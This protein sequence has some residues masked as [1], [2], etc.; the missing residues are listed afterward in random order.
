MWWMDSGTSTLNTLCL[1]V[2]F[3]V[4]HQSSVNDISLDT[5]HYREVFHTAYT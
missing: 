5:I 3:S 4:G 2:L 1:S